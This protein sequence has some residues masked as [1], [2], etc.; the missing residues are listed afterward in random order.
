VGY[1]HTE[2]TMKYSLHW[3]LCPF[4]TDQKPSLFQETNTDMKAH[5]YMFDRI[6]EIE[7]SP[8]VDKAAMIGAAVAG[9]RTEQAAH[10][11]AITELDRRIND[12]LAIEYHVE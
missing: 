8:H 6:I 9:L 2:A 5:G 10:Q 4:E 1:H 7:Q 3:K 11:N 12:M